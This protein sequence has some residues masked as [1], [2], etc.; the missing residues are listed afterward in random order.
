[1]VREPSASWRPLAMRLGLSDR[2]VGLPQVIPRTER[3]S[4]HTEALLILRG[5][6]DPTHPRIDDVF[7]GQVR[8]KLVERVGRA[9]QGNQRHVA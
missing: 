6:E 1:M 3:A 9:K 4:Q 5:L 8:R 2:H 7:Q